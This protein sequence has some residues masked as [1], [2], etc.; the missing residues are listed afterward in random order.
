MTAEMQELAQQR[1][2][3]P[4]PIDNQQLLLQE[5]A[6]GDNSLCTTRTQE[7]RNS[8]QQMQ[9]KRHQIFQRETG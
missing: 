2:Q 9:K 1:E 7:I 5:K 3:L 6:V 8:G 4:G